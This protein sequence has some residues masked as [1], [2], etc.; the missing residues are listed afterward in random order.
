M[1]LYRARSAE[2]RSQFGAFS[3]A[4]GA[5]D[6]SD[7]VATGNGV[8]DAGTY[9]RG[10]N[11]CDEDAGFGGC[12]NGDCDEVEHSARADCVVNRAAAGPA[13]GCNAENARV[14]ACEVEG[15]ITCCSPR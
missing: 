9:D 7:D 13:F 15:D 6:C 12:F 1:V 10:H 14:T 8:A 11:R 2:A 3:A 5:G 4:C